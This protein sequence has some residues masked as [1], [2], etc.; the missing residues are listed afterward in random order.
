[1]CARILELGLNL[2]TGFCL[3]ELPMQ[4][5]DC[6]CALP[7]PREYAK[8]GDMTKEGPLCLRPYMLNYR[9]DMGLRGYIEPVRS[10]D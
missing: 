4:C 6:D 1:M 10:S 8:R 9:S 3:R 5:T 7:C 2:S